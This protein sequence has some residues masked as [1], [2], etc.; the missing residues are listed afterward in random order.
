MASNYNPYGQIDAMREQLKKMQS[1]K[2]VDLEKENELDAGKSYQAK[3]I[4]GPLPE[5]DHLRNKVTEEANTVN[6]Q[7][8]DALKRRFASMGALNSGSYIKQ[9]EIQN[10]ESEQRRS[11]ASSEINFQEAQARR[12]LEKEESQKAYQSEEALKGRTFE[13]AQQ[14]Y[15]RNMQK[16]LFNADMNFKNQVFQFDSGTKLGALEMQARELDINKQIAA[17]NEANTLFDHDDDTSWQ[18][19][20]EQA[21]RGI[22]GGKPTINLH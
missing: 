8:Q 6:S 17:M 11:Q 14:R 13:G 16:D 9:A 3:A 1:P 19:Y 12:A 2:P 22:E 10:N 20:Y 15:S 4:S 21:L 7:N 5:Y 18:E